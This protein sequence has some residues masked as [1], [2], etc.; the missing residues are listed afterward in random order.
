MMIKI[1][2]HERKTISV[3]ENLTDALS[4]H[5]IANYLRL[6]ELFLLH[7]HN[8]RQES[9]KTAKDKN[10]KSK[11]YYLDALEQIKKKFKSYYKPGLKT[12]EA[13]FTSRLDN[14]EEKI[15]YTIAELPAA[16]IIP[17]TLAGNTA[18]KALISAGL[19]E[20]EATDQILAY[21]AQRGFKGVSF[22]LEISTPQDEDAGGLMDIENM[23]ISVI[24]DVAIFKTV[25]FF[26]KE[27]N[28]F[29]DSVE[30]QID[31]TKRTVYHELQHLFVDIIQKI[32]GFGRYGLGPRSASR[33]NLPDKSP[34][35]LQTYSQNVL[36]LFGDGMKELIKA[37]KQINPDQL[38][39]LKKIFFKKIF[40]M[41]L[42][43]IEKQF[44]NKLDTT[45]VNK[46]YG[47]IKDELENIKTYDQKMYNYALKVFHDEVF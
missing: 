24:Y 33:G 16:A 43:P 32:T 20:E 28:K 18:Q 23:T 45:N 1:K 17:H 19:D 6:V 7:K 3:S 12:G 26:E 42:S 14:L 4:Q 46:Y 36:S 25:L 37:N 44:Y 35:E 40:N 34:H 31:Y 22:D 41:S 39:D 38:E 47:Y 15:S 9:L 8:K 11:N 5:Y 10:P 21:F 13:D 30:K 29:I 27:I 2:L